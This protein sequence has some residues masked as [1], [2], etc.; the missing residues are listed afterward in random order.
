MERTNDGKV[1]KEQETDSYILGYHPNSKYLDV[2]HGTDEP[3][4]LRA[5]KKVYTELRNVGDQQYL[6]QTW[7][8]GSVCDLT[9]KPRTVEVQVKKK[10]KERL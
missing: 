6:A 4:A 10:K 1:E 5:K 8:D 2:N 3:K 9:E 7:K